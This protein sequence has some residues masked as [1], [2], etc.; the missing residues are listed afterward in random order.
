MVGSLVT[1]EH[2]EL[3]V[4]PLPKNKAGPAF[5]AGLGEKGFGM[6]GGAQ[7]HLLLHFR[8]TLRTFTSSPQ[9]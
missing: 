4:N 7:K 1:F 6:H 2:Q 5:N 3:A 9:V 8:D